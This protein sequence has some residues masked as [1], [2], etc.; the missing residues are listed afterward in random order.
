MHFK[1][2]IGSMPLKHAQAKL[3]QVI[4]KHSNWNIRIGHTAFQ[5]AIDLKGLQAKSHNRYH[6]YV[7]IDGTP[8][9]MRR[10]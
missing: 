10:M 4:L 9:S 2:I 5:I 8:L 6:R 1:T 7:T 3:P